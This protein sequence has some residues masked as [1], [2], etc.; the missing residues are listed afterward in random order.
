MYGDAFLNRSGSGEV[1]AADA[2]GRN[3]DGF[4]RVPPTSELEMLKGMPVKFTG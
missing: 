4:R 3:P 1:G 2:L